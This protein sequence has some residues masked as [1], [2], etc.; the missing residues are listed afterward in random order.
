MFNKI[1][2]ACLLGLYGFS[3]VDFPLIQS[4]FDVI[5]LLYTVINFKKQVFNK[6][7]AF[8]LVLLIIYLLN[9]YNDFSY[10]Y[11]RWILMLNILSNYFRNIPRFLDSSMFFWNSYSL[12]LILSNAIKH[13]STREFGFY[14]DEITT[15]LV[16]VLSLQ[17]RHHKN[18]LYPTLI[19]FGILSTRSILS[20]AIALV[21]YSFI[22]NRRHGKIFLYPVFFFIG[23]FFLFYYRFQNR[24]KRFLDS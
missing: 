5:L 11:F 16:I 4:G 6:N 8:V 1:F 12:F 22:L 18:L 2:T 7:L 23:I 3:K 13:F 15:I 24:F 20:S 10:Q 14:S 9:N 19:L 17:I 21:A